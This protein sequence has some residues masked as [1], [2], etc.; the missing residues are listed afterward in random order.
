MPSI[1]SKKQ[2][3]LENL[4]Y[5]FI[6]ASPGGFKIYVLL[7]L[8][9]LSSNI[10][11]A[12]AND[13]SIVGFLTMITAI[14]AGTQLLHIIPKKNNTSDSEA[15]TV[16]KS[17]LIKLL[18]YISII[19]I[20]FY[21]TDLLILKSLS[22]ST[23]AAVLLFISS[24]YWIF[25]HYYLA[26]E[27]TKQ[28]LIMEA[29]TWSITTTGFVALHILGKL[30]TQS[31]LITISASYFISFAAPLIT[32]ILHRETQN[33][34]IICNSA[35]IGLS[36]L[37]SGGVINL[38]PSICYNLGNTALAGTIGLMINISS[39]TLT[40]IRAQL[41]KK[42][43][44]ISLAISN[45]DPNTIALCRNT[46]LAITKTICIS[47]L[48]LQP[49]NVLTAHYTQHSGSLSSTL[50][51]SLLITTLIC[52]PQL[53]AINSIV[54][55][56]IGKSSSML[57]A[58]SGHALLAI[59]TTYTFHLTFN[60][61]SITFISFLVSSSL[62]FIGRNKIIDLITSKELRNIAT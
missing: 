45:K 59:S 46:Q 25:R 35:S 44:E 22:S 49:I 36:N 32:T 41:Y 19:C 43:P 2:K 31:A 62:L 57:L 37:V 30:T 26:R 34:S 1:G 17:A 58:N 29:W 24:I 9:L 47:S 33:V 48:A 5:L 38:A 55:N 27:A 10:Q 14:G 60:N 20:T 23:E 51:Y 7:F 13:L 12:L 54:A 6:S 28:L 21:L 39:V 11:G 56:F 4:I 53:S 16:L 42:S 18:P 61:P 3:N 15:R 50:G 40:L 8:G 52:L